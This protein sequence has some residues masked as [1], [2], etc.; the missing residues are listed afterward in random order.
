MKV[1]TLEQRPANTLLMVAKGFADI[2]RD[3]MAEC[4]EKN[5]QFVNYVT[6]YRI[7]TEEYNISFFSPKKDLCETCCAYNKAEGDEKLKLE[8]YYN[9]HI[10]EKEL[11]DLK[12]NECEC[13]VWDESNGHRGINELGSCVL[14]FLNK[15]AALGDKDLI[16][17]S[18]NC[19]GQQK[20]KFMVALYMYAITHFNIRIITHKYLIKGHTQNEGDSTHSL[21]ERQIKR[22]LKAGP[23]YTS[24]SFISAVR[25]TRRI[26]MI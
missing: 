12:T 8:E 3:Y 7:F 23:M 25:G 11:F 18:D 26:F 15:R 19:S 14:K 1:I 21:I 17:Y 20:N 13:F 10:L 9:K 4:K 22:Q 16:L 24:E 6:F 2:H 5:N